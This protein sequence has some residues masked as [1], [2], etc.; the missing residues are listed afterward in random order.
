MASCAPTAEPA[1]VP[2]MKSAAASST[3]CRASPAAKPV[4]H[5]I[6]TEPPPLNTNARLILQLSFARD[7]CPARYP[8]GRLG[9]PGLARSG[10]RLLVRAARFVQATRRVAE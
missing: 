8:A 10:P 6:P 3:P 1:D 9:T 4:C 2:T 5:A 7:S